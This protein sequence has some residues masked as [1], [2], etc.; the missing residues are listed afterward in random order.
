VLL[1]GSELALKKPD[2]AHI[3]PKAKYPFMQQRALVLNLSGE[4]LG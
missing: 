1:T 3:S 4:K 2:T